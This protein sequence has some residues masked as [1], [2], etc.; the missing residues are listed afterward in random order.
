MITPT[1]DSIQKLIAQ[2]KPGAVYEDAVSLMVT[3]F[4]DSIIYDK[5]PPIS[6]EEAR[7]TLQVVMSAYESMEHHDIVKITS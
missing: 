1:I 6:G 3:D 5:E 7:S 4:V 2:E